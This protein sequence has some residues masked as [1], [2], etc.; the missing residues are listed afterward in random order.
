MENENNMILSAPPIKMIKLSTGETI[1][2]MLELMPVPP[3]AEAAVADWKVYNPYL[4]IVVRLPETRAGPA[5][6]VTIMEEWLPSGVVAEAVCSLFSDNILTVVDVN[7]Q[8]AANYRKK[9]M[10]DLLTREV[11]TNNPPMK[12]EMM[13]SEEEDIELEGEEFKESL[14][15]R[16]VKFRK[17]FN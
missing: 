15:E 11:L 3:D 2:G 12:N 16:I 9:V 6:T 1:V 10:N 5:K 8:F 14:E 7:E 17:N 13:L 4:L